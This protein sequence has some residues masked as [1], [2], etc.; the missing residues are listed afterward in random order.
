MEANFIM[1]LIY[2]IG[3]VISSILGYASVLFY[4]PPA[5]R[6][7]NKIIPAVIITGLL[8]WIFVSFVVIGVVMTGLIYSGALLMEKLINKLPSEKQEPVATSKTTVE[9]EKTDEGGLKQPLKKQVSG[10]IK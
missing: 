3:V 6:D 1:L 5:I 2:I 10:N 8:S 9:E 7:N 4:V